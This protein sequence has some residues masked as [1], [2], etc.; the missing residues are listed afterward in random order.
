MHRRTLLA[1]SATACASPAWAL[2]DARPNPLLA[3][4]PGAWSGSLTY[5]DWRN[6]DKLV[7]LPCKL[8]AALL[9]PEELALFYVF[10]DG[11][12]KV[13]HS[14]ERMGFDFKAGTLTWLSGASQP[15][16][17]R[18]VVT[19]TS[20]GSEESRI[21]FER[22]VDDRTDKYV[23]AVSRTALSLGKTEFSASGAQTFRNNYQFRRGEA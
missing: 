7:T 16:T 4:V 9:A 23:M 2:Y 22:S 17:T 20:S 13:V 10:D 5:R 1:A 6:P 11:P 21:Q 14:Y 12:G 19:S 15:S 18:C 3:L 8:S